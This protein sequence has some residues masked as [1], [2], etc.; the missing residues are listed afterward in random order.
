MRLGFKISQSQ[1]T[2][3]VPATRYSQHAKYFQLIR[4]IHFP[5]PFSTNLRD[6]ARLRNLR[7][8]GQIIVLSA[9][10]PVKY[11]IRPV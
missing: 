6:D 10:W 7:F 11:K 4:E 3:E 8:T 2:K 1:S 5:D 9:E